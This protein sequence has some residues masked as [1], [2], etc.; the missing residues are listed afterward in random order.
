[1]KHL[2]YNHLRALL[3]TF[4]MAM[5]AWPAMAEKT[6]QID[7]IFYSFNIN[8]GEAQ[9]FYAREYPRKQCTI[10]ET[11][12][13]EGKTY[14]VTEIGDQSFGSMWW[15]D[16]AIS[17]GFN[18]NFYGLYLGEAIV[19]PNSVREIQ[20]YAFA[21]CRELKYLS[22]PQS[23]NWIGYRA[24]TATHI[25]EVHIHNLAA[26]CDIDFN[27]GDPDDFYAEPMGSSPVR[28]TTKV[29]IDGSPLSDHLVIP[30]GVTTIKQNAFGRF[31]MTTVS[32][33]ASVTSIGHFTFAYCSNLQKIYCW[34]PVPPNIEEN[35]FSDY[36]P[37]LYVPEG[38]KESYQSAPFWGN[39]T[40]I[41][42]FDPAGIDEVE[43][44]G[45][46]GLPTEYYNLQGVKV[47]TAAPGE[48]PSLAPGT[49]I[50][51]RGDKTAKVLIR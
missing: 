31:Q 34:N 18:G 41:V 4:L 20:S 13:A 10:P 49:Y 30:N 27:I 2:S 16:K 44:D 40:N 35:T 14:T 3:L 12:T 15:E 25:Q 5:A 1:M 19:I 42:E 24:F 28:A 45:D 36:S 9:V 38:S 23:I 43:E 51:R 11:I 46:A 47:A 48:Q 50:T 8:T 33:P 6:V 26:W 29:Y 39:F 17:W 32:I 37:T 22:M 21:Y 7:N